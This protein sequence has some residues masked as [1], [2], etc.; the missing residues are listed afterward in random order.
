MT[1]KFVHLLM[2]IFFTAGVGLD[3]SEENT[4]AETQKV[5]PFGLDLYFQN[6]VG[7][8]TAFKAY[9]QDPYVV[10]NLYLY[11]HFK[12]KNFWDNRQI[13]IQ[14]EVRA[15]F[16]WLSQ[17]NPFPGK[18]S[19]K[20][21]WG[22]FKL[23]AE[24]KNALSAKDLG[25]SFSPAFKLEAPLSKSSRDS[26]RVIGLGGFFN[27][28]W[29]KWGFFFNYKP[30]G[31]GYVYSAP[32]KKGACAP[33]ALDEDKVIDE[34]LCKVAGRQTAFQLKNTVTTGY[35]ADGHTIT[36]GFRT[37]HSFLRQANIGEK[38][39]E[40]PNSG[41]MEATLGWVE[42]SYDFNTALPTTLIVG[43]SGYQNPYDVKQ[44]FRMPFFSFAEPKKNLTEAY[45]AVNVSL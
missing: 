4:H 26:N 36:L 22:D 23:R 2:V 10:S 11:P 40:Q 15:D 38:P 21:Y 39:D 6:S 43:L 35:S 27:A 13:K 44:G 16:E 42:Y 20:F 14:A 1:K 45:V 29:S 3:A 30:V 18:L 28:N 37:Y 32:Y 41:V 9:E 31:V 34:A 25:F 19:N 8:S 12:T 7:A 17:N 33:G 24:L 5:P